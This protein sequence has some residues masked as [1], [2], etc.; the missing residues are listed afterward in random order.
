MKSAGARKIAPTRY[1]PS[2]P[3]PAEGGGAA[4]TGGSA[5][6][7]PALMSRL[8]PCLVRRGGCCLELRGDARRVARRLEEVLEQSPLAR[9]GGRAE[10]RRLL[11]RHVEHDG[12]RGA[13]RCF[14][15][16]GDR[17]R[18]DARRDV[19]VAG[20]EAALLRPDLRGRRGGEVLHERLDR[21]GVA[22][23]DEEV[24]TDLDRAGIRAG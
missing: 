20:P 6:I 10:R 7:P 14:R 24:A 4:T 3:G 13:D 19:L 23:R 5:V 2:R 9:A 12:L 1:L 18:I 8:L 15:G 16:A 11:V 17:I 22:E 21:R